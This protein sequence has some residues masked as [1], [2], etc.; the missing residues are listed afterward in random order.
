VQTG[1]PK[2]IKPLR[3]KTV[4][5]RNSLSGL[6]T[7]SNP[8]PVSNQPE[9]APRSADK[10]SQTMQNT[11]RATV[12]AAGAGVSQSSPDGDV[13]MEKVTAV[14][15]ALAAG[16]YNVPASA[17]ATKMVDSMLGKPS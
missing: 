10:N 2:P 17:V 11:D 3:R 12:S 5:I 6:N 15:Q 4:E 7:I 1:A 13:R 16:T 14:Q 8:A 9:T